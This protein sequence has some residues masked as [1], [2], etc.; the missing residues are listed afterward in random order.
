MSPAARSFPGEH[1]ERG[2]YHEPGGL[3]EPFQKG[4]DAGAH[5]AAVQAR[6]VR[7][8]AGEQVQ[9]IG[10]GVREPKSAR[11]PG[12]HLGRR[13]RCPALFKPDVVLGGNVREDGDLFAAQAGSAAPGTG[14]QADVLWAQSF[15]STAQECGQL[16]LV[17]SS[18]M[19]RP[20]W[21]SLVP[22]MP[23]Y[24]SAGEGR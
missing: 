12:Q 24:G 9:V 15:A 6:A 22:T 16:M 17:H 5:V 19:R 3:R 11:D 14:R 4:E 7:G 20:V 10:L 18:S 1:I 21:L 23:G 2:G 8:R 13:A